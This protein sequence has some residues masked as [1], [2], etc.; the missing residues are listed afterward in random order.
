MPHAN[1]RHDRIFCLEE[2]VWDERLGLTDV[3]SVLPTFEL[4]QR[5]GIVD[6]FV[7]RS[8]YG[9]PEFASYME[10]RPKGRLL[11]SYGTLYLAFHGNRDGLSVGTET[12]N[13]DRL[14]ELIGSFDGGVLH[15]SS[16]SV[17]TEETA[18]RF[19][20]STGARLISGYNRRVSWLDS[21]TLETAL[22][23]YLAS[24]SELADGI[25]EFRE[26]Y[27]SL[28]KYL[29]WVAYSNRAGRRHGPGA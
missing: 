2:S 16:C 13:L 8:V 26:R 25:R 6:Q 28:I 23:G 24:S 15:L 5:M 4:L 14:G 17:L 9:A 7:H 3:T 10:A 19:L 27:D 11:R 21:I 29:D 12:V 20:K 22:L 1:L 18:K